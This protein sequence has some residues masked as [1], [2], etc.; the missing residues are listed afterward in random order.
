[1]LHVPFKSLCLGISAALWIVL[2]AGATAQAFAPLPPPTPGGAFSFGVFYGESQRLSVNLGLDYAGLFGT[3]EILDFDASTSSYS[4]SMTV[5]ITDP[6]FWEGPYSRRL[7]AGIRSLEPDAIQ[8]GDYILH[9]AELGISFGRRLS[10]VL[11]FS[12]GAGVGFYDFD[13]VTALPG[14]IEAYVAEVGTD[15]SDVFADVNI[16][17]DWSSSFGWQRRGAAA[18]V[19]TRIGD[20]D[21]G[22]YVTASAQANYYYPVSNW[23]ELRA[24][25]LVQF[26]KTF[27]SDDTFPIFRNFTGGGP[28]TVRGYSEATLGPTSTVPGTTDVAYS[29][30]Q[31][32]VFSG[33]ELRTS[34]GDNDDLFGVTFVDFGNVYATSGD[35]DWDTIRGSFGL[36]VQWETDIGPFSVFWSQPFNDKAGD[37]LTEVQ[38]LLGLRL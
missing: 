28:G 31:F 25:G 21:A 10:P 34:L 3:D 37:Q 19:E 2:P 13:D 24:R 20:T 33:L 29:G 18:D 26:G 11:G 4:S 30:G 36:G 14:Y 16:S 9:Q 15:F 23:G 22:A 35:F 32:A 8:A 17:W 5:S 12:V 6:D 38:F 1:M 27:G 7:S